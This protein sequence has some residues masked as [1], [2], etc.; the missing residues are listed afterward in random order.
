MAANNAELLKKATRE[1]TQK[2]IIA[3]FGEGP[4]KLNLGCGSDMKKDHINIDVLDSADLQL[5]LEV[6]KLPF[7]KGSVESIFAA[8]IFEHLHSFPKLMNECHR[9]LKPNGT[10]QVH[11]PCYPA[12]EVFHDPTHVRVFTD[13]TFQ[14][15]HGGTFLH[16]HCGESYGYKPWNRLL[17]KRINGWELVASLSK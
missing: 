1:M 4:Y 14:Y 2:D 16:T 12:S 11:V 8:H 9:V 13:K 5:D 6:G 10:L 17:Q 3:K 7:P 15:F